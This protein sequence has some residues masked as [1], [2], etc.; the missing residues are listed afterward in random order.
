MTTDAPPATSPTAPVLRWSARARTI[1]ENGAERRRVSAIRDPSSH[2]SGD[3]GRGYI[4]A[5]PVGM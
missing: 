4:P 1:P 2:I 3:D 5:L